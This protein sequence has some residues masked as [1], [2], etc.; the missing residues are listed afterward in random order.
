MVL[1]LVLGLG[2]SRCS[3]GGLMVLWVRHELSQ[4][5]WLV[6]AGPCS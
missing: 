3:S 2:Y 4:L 5:L 1:G 6:N